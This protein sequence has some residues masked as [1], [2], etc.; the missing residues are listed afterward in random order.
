[1][2]PKKFYLLLFCFFCYSHILLAQNLDVNTLLSLCKTDIGHIDSIM[3]ENS[4]GKKVYEARG[5]F[6]IVTYTYT[7]A[8]GASSTV[9]SVHIGQKPGKKYFEVEYGVWQK[10]DARDFTD[11]ISKAGF[12]KQV[13]AIPDIGGSS[14]TFVTYKKGTNVISYREEPQEGTGNKLYI[15]SISSDSH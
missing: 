15:F 5:N 6:T 4:Y 12:M 8:K 9:R 13:Q 11:R 7:G 10:E 14:S 2:T 1:M 3:N